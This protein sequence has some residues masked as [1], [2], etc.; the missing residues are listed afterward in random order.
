MTCKNFMLLVE[1]LGL[2]HRQLG[3]LSVFIELGKSHS[4]CDCKTAPQQF[5]KDS[6]QEAEV[7]KCL[8][9]IFIKGIQ[10]SALHIFANNFRYDTDLSSSSRGGGVPKYDPGHQPISI[11]CAF[12]VA[13][14]CWL[15]LRKKHLL[16]QS[17][18]T[19]SG[20]RACKCCQVC[21]AEANLSRR[22]QRG[23]YL[24]SVEIIESFQQRVILSRSES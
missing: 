4:L 2:S 23:Q 10:S 7:M 24:W 21:V 17:R 15:S 12:A 6:M 14:G 1:I 8:K 16:A 9:K 5:L 3:F 13:Q 19:S 11:G 20:W 22:Y 18:E